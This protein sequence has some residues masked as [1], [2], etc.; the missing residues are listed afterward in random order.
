M[1][2][3]RVQRLHLGTVELNDHYRYRY[4]PVPRQPS[5]DPSAV[6]RKAKVGQP[7]MAHNSTEK[8]RS[9]VISGFPHHKYNPM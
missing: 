6:Q 8:P 3:K 5:D 9:Y 2:E 1:E 4:L 7:R